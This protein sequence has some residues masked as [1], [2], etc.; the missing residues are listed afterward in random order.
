MKV[1]NGGGRSYGTIV[2][3]ECEAG[4][5][6]SGH[7]VILCMSNGTW[8]GDVPTCSSKLQCLHFTEVGIKAMKKLRI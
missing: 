2:R 3:Y 1:L 4:Y 7:P 8:S 6:R 5:V